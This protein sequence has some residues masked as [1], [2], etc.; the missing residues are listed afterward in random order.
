MLVHGAAASMSDSGTCMRR[1]TQPG[2]AP[3]GRTGEAAAF[4][5]GLHLLL[6]NRNTPGSQVELPLTQSSGSR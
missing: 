2:Q 4:R 1:R 6:A 5:R 3:A